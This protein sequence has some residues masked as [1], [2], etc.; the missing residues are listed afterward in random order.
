MK[1]L[2]IDWTFINRIR[3]PETDQLDDRMRELCDAYDRLIDLAQAQKDRVIKSLGW[4]YIWVVLSGENTDKF[5]CKD[6][7]QN[8]KSISYN[9]DYFSLEK[10]WKNG[11]L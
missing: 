1:T 6:I 4:S 7:C 9:Y 10:N 2:R 8:W 5:H 3:P 11:V